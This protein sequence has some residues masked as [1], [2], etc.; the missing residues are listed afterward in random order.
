MDLRVLSQRLAVARLGPDAAWP[1]PA[2]DSGFFSV[3]R[4]DGELSIV[5]A[6]DATPA[7]AQ[8]ETGWRALEVAG[9]L[10]F[11]MIG[12]MSSLTAP[13]SAV[14]VSVFVLSTFDTDYL[15]V[16]AASLERAVGAL[17]NAGH[18]VHAG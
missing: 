11:A 16:H 14:D 3:T 9:P 12:V 13:L 7:G 1:V 8:V 6:E 5:C 10:D 15:L 17:R 18:A 4:T 2:A